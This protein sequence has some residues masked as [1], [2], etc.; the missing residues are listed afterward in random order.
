M[1]FEFFE[2]GL[3]PYTPWNKDLNLKAWWIKLSVQMNFGFI[4]VLLGIY[5]FWCTYIKLTQAK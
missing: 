2:L 4:L 3:A 5:T 1:K